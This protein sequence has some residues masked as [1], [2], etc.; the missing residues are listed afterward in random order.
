M[1]ENLY[2]SQGGHMSVAYEFFRPERLEFRS[3][4]DMVNFIVDHYGELMK[5]YRV[6][7]AQNLATREKKVNAHNQLQI[8]RAKEEHYR[9]SG[10]NLTEADKIN[11]EETKKHLTALREE[12][13][14]HCYNGEELEINQLTM[15][16]LNHS[17]LMAV[18]ERLDAL[19]R[20]GI[21]SVSRKIVKLALVPVV[22]LNKSAMKQTTNSG[23][24]KLFRGFKQMLNSMPDA[25]EESILATMDVELEK[26][27]APKKD[28]DDEVK[29]FS[30]SF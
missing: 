1:N 20:T 21:A 30:F 24:R 12:N 26:H 14:V 5:V 2:H 15:L 3:T 25:L 23:R 10:V 11:L 13:D 22:K 19:A 4:E 16:I 29:S 28:K 7:K 18:L 17:W 9:R 8:E 27:K 6:M